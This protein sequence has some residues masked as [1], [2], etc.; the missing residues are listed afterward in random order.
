[1]SNQNAPLVSIVVPVCNVAAY[2]P[3]CL[4]SLTGQTLRE[5]EV[6]CVDDASTDGSDGILRAWAAKDDRIRLAFHKE[7]M[8]A[9]AGRKE[10]TL[11]SRGRYLLF[12]DP[13]DVLA[14][15]ACALLTAEMERDPVDI[16]HFTADAVGENGVSRQRVDS[17]SRQLIPMDGALP[18]A[19]HPELLDA[20]FVDGLFSY[21]LWNKCY[22][23]DFARQAM[24]HCPD[25][26]FPKAQ[27]LLAFYVLLYFAQSYRGL[28]TP[29]L[30]HYTLGRG[31]T[32][33]AKLSRKQIEAYAAQARIPAALDAFIAGS[34]GEARCAAS[35]DAVYK[36]LLRDSV[37]RLRQVDDADFDFMWNA[38]CGSWGPVETIGQL[39]AL[40]PYKYDEWGRKMNLLRREDHPVEQVKTVGAFY[41]RLRN[42]GAQR[43][44]AILCQVWR[45]MG[46]RVVLFTDEEP[47]EEDYPTPPDTIRVVLP[48]IGTNE[49]SD[50]IPRFR[51]LYDAVREYHIDLFINHAWASVRMLWEMLTVQ[52][53]GAAYFVHCH[54]VFGSPMVMNGMQR[55]LWAMPEIYR[56]ADGVL[57]LSRTDAAYWRHFN[58]RVMQV[59]NPLTFTPSEI[60]L[61]PL[62]GHTV[63]WVGR[64]SGEKRPVQ[65][66]EI[67]RRVREA[68]PDARLIM[69][70]DGTAQMMQYVQDAVR[71]DGLEDAVELAGFQT[72][73]SPYYA[74][75]DVFLCTSQYEG[76][77]LTLLEAQCHGLP[78]VCY[79]M[80]YLSVFEHHLG[81]VVVPQEGKDAAAAEVIR[82]LEDGELRRRLGAEGRQNVDAYFAIDLAEQWRQVFAMSRQPAAPLPDRDSEEMLILRTWHQL[83]EQQFKVTDM[84]ARGKQKQIDD[85]RETVRQLQARE[86]QL[87]EREKQAGEVQQ[88]LEEGRRQLQAREQEL[89]GEK[90]RLEQELQAREKQFAQREQGLRQQLKTL[91]RQKNYIPMPKKGPFRNARKRAATFLRV[92]L[93]DGFGGVGD[94]MRDL[95]HR[96]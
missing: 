73:V 91:Q 72:D 67:F 62:D 64:M 63:V 80:P 74:R 26:Y 8:T 22:R 66:V 19:E 75:G 12:V 77:P 58:G 47:T 96:G 60:P 24:A 94:L 17:V 84:R 59:I 18:D 68:I 79:D 50:T 16:L 42:G 44:A 13:D 93:I 56:H 92:L 85:L 20:C 14:E 31:I 88:R 83:A 82:I 51:A 4:A 70:G 57:A 34:G 40:V 15:D 49:L 10:G 2:L 5:I 76:A 89:S 55:M 9:A 11:M 3:A 39:C 38:F 30:Y 95:K 86:K 43:V 36:R 29:P 52:A 32:G 28:E 61:S 45:D 71:R 1:M 23:G 33:G 81:S 6:I 65:V 46:L 78:V 53:A 37:S 48:V 54:N 7:N 25:G 27:D 41:H 21:Q 35:R 87:S 69:V 90:K